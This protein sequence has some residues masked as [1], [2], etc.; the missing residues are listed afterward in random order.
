MARTGKSSG[1]GRSGQRQAQQSRRSRSPAKEFSPSPGVRVVPK[2]ASDGSETWDVVIAP[3]AMQK[4]ATAA[5][6][7]EAQLE[8]LRGPL[9]LA[10][11]SLLCLQAIRARAPSW[12]NRIEHLPR[13]AYL[14]HRERQ[15]PKIGNKT[16]QQVI[17]ADFVELRKAGL[18]HPQMDGDRGRPRDRQTIATWTCGGSIASPCEVSNCTRP[19]GAASAMAR[20]SLVRDYGLPYFS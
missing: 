10:M 14:A 11:Y 15:I 9:E 7:I 13:E 12:P 2:R 1:R 6:V 17:A 8:W 16:W 4:L 3:S 18:D 5:G 19:H 20:A